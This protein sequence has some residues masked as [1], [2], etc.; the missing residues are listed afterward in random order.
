[1]G[2]AAGRFRRCRDIRFGR[3]DGLG[4]DGC[5]LGYRR[6]CRFGSRVSFRSGGCHRFRLLARFGGSGL[7]RFGHRG[8]RRLRHGFGGRRYVGF[9]R[10][11]RCRLGRLGFFGTRRF[12]DFLHGFAGNGLDGRRRGL[13]GSGRVCRLDSRCGDRDRRG[14]DHVGVGRLRDI[15]IG[16]IGRF[17]AF[18]G[19]I[20][21]IALDEDTLLAHLDLDRT[22]TTRT[23]G[24]TDFRGLTARQRNLLA[25]CR[26]VRAAQRL[27]QF[28][29]VAVGDVIFNR[30]QVDTSRA[31][32]FQQHVGWHF[33]FDSELG[34][35]VTRH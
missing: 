24:L 20:V 25:F 16:V 5:R 32:L 19:H 35:G 11:D 21:C 34:D 6:F 2:V 15:Q 1:V 22:G 27:E 33:Q 9:G 3:A 13:L 17:H 23:V 31:Q 7:G 26:A 10:G 29:L 4:L 18:G 12:D 28:R 8:R 14:I 30:F